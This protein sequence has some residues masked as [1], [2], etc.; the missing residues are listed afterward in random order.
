VGTVFERSHVPL[1]KWLFANH[2]LCASKKGVS[3]HQLHRL[4]GVTYKTAWFM[5]HRIRAAMAPITTEPMGGPGQPVQADETYFGTRDSL[6]GQPAEKKKG[7][8]RKMQV[9]GLVSGGKARMFKVKSANMDTVHQILVKHTNTTAELHTDESALYREIGQDYA[10]HK[11][12]KHTEDE[13]VRDG[14]HTNSIE[15][16]FSVFKRGMRGVYQHCSEKHLQR[17]LDEFDFRYNNLIALEIDDTMR[18]DEAIK[19]VA[20]KRLTYRRTSLGVR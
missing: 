2:L 6:R 8:S 18:A 16:Y 13:Y 12:V 3:A 15:N 7:H 19:G 20:N 1:H 9:V 17:Y 10:A 11:T 14:A 4:L 5:A